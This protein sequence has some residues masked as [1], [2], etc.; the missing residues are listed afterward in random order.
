MVDNEKKKFVQNDDWK[1]QKH[2]MPAQPPKT[3]SQLLV[4]SEEDEQ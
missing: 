4:E 2:S 1:S 3:P